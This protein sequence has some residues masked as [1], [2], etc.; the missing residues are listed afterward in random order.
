MKILEK[1]RKDAHIYKKYDNAKTP[2]KRCL[3][4]DKLSDEEKQKLIKIKEGLNIIELKK[5]VEKVLNDVL[6]YVHQP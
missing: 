5:N 4:S 6:K 2:Y 3:E 1:E